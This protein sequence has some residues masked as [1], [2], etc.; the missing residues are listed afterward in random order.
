[1]TDW[2]ALAA[3]GITFG[4]LGLLVWVQRRRNGERGAGAAGGR[5]LLARE[6]LALGAQHAAHLLEVDGRTVLVVTGPGTVSL[7]VARLPAAG[8]AQPRSGP[9]AP[10]RAGIPR[11]RERARV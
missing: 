7:P 6:R 5:R 8:R 11:L 1:M 9:G 4:L 10:G 3:P 2:Q